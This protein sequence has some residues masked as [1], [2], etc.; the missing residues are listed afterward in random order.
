MNKFCTFLLASLVVIPS[1]G[2]CK[3]SKADES[4]D[5]EVVEVKPDTMIATVFFAGDLMQHKPQVDAA[6]ACGKGK[7]YDYSECFRL[8][9]P[10]IS[11]ADLA[12]GNLEVTLGGAPY[13]GYPRFSAPDA[14]LD[15]ILDAGFDV[16]TTANNHCLDRDAK[17]VKRTNGVLDSLKVSHLGCY[18]DQEERD[19]EYPVVM[20]VKGIRIALLTY[21]YGTNGIPVTK[22]NV[23]NLIDTAQIRKDIEVAKSKQPDL[24]I[25]SMHWGIEY[26]TK[27][28][29]EQRKL[30]HW[31]VDNGVDHVIGGHPHV[32][33]PF[34]MYTS[35]VDSME[36]Y[37]IYSLGN[38]VSNQNKPQCKGGAMVTLT[39]QK[40]V[41]GDSTSVSLIDTKHQLVSVSRPAMNAMHSYRIL[42]DDCPDEE[43][44]STEKRAHEE[45]LHLASPVLNAY[46]PK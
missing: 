5:A 34:E 12:V 32:V 1:F 10:I 33:E 6:W 30:A 46:V 45:Y 25:A 40:I 36:H 29:A 24:I 23:V 35:P 43:M 21:T 31:L 7:K 41:D 9:K 17:G 37:I 38:F 16:I 18:V 20:D 19:R 2:S 28:T 4:S 44:N 8:V 27:E 26:V 42:P 3:G 13:T 39:F 22:P 15:A 14:Y 11:A